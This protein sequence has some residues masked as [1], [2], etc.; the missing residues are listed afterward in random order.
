MIDLG[1][2]PPTPKQNLGATP[3]TIVSEHDAERKPQY[4]RLEFN[5]EQA[6]AAGLNKCSIGDVYEIT[7]RLRAKRLGNYGWEGSGSSDDSPSAEFEVIS[8]DSPTEIDDE[9]AGPKP[10]DK[11]KRETREPDKGPKIV[12]PPMDDDDDD[13]D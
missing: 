13:G 4:P 11:P 10:K 7:V 5:G 1:Y 2:T 6:A 8:A 9:E 12:K 3:V